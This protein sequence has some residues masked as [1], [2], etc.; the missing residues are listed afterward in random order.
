MEEVEEK[1]RGGGGKERWQKRKTQG[2]TRERWRKSRGRTGGRRR[3]GEGGEMMGSRKRME[4]EEE[5]ARGGTGNGEDVQ[6][7]LI[8]LVA[9]AWQE[10]PAVL[11]FISVTSL[12]G[13]VGRG[14]P[15]PLTPAPPTPVYRS[16][17]TSSASP[18]SSK[19][20]SGWVSNHP[21][22]P[23]LSSDVAPHTVTHTAGA[24]LGGF[25]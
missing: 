17:T 12:F 20:L 22:P 6:D 21:P 25:P 4:E 11:R 15:L 16:T 9:A 24:A 10:T 8:S 14:G 23:F 3:E 19:L 7:S 13:G 18:Q 1:E 2:K 5:E